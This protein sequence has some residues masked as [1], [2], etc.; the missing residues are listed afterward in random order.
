MVK[1]KFDFKQ[2]LL[3]SEV[4]EILGITEGTMR[5]KISQG[6]IPSEFYEK[7]K[8]AYKFNPAYIDYAINKKA[9][10]TNKENK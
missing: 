8:G 4:A 7:Y 9:N 10:K 1:K 5:S 2:V 6:H 3:L